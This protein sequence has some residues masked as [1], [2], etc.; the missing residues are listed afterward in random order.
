MLGPKNLSWSKAPLAELLRLSWPICVS[1][2]SYSIMTL[3]DTLFVG[4]LGKAALAGMGL[5]GTLAFAA[6][7][8]GIGLLRGVKV[9]ISQAIGA[10]VEERVPLYAAAGIIIAIV[11][12]AVVI[13]LGQLLVLAV[14][15]LAASTQA[16][17][18]G[19]EYLWV[20]LLGA[21]I[22]FLFC[23]T[24]ETSYGIGNTKSPMVASVVANLVN[25]SLDYLFI[26]EFELG[27]SGAAWATFV[28][29]FLELGI[30]LVLV[31]YP[32]FSRLRSGL[33]YLRAVLRVGI[34]T[35]VQFAIE[36]GAFTL[37]TILIAA[38]SET[39][40]AAHQIALSVIQFAFLP[41]IAISEAASVMVGQAVGANRDELVPQIARLALLLSLAY[42]SFC[43]LVF[44]VGGE[45]ISGLFGSD[46]EVRDTA[47]K[48]LYLGA[49]FQFGDACNIIGRG[50]LRGTGDVKWSARVCVAVAWLTLPPLTWLFGYGFSMGAFGGWLA[51]VLEIFLGAGLLWWRLQRGGWKESA[52]AS[53]FALEAAVN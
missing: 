11:M 5:A 12:G 46:A 36:V 40:M 2:L 14:P 48:I 38:M 15:S 16:G 44:F 21:P 42:A 20:R 43:T 52:K 18:I 17:Q 25:I 47:T 51:I 31:R 29:T 4:N 24:R 7:V 41:Y 49:L 27:A 13:V 1:M 22:V 28:A 26:V 37:L 9:V 30:L 6:M 23:T 8:F 39:E 53:R 34:S 19:A 32:G 33:R 3:A 45:T 50:V 10:G 35:G